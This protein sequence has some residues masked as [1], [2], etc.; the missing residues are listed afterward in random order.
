MIKLELDIRKKLDRGRWLSQK[1]GQTIGHHL[2]MAP[3]VNFELFIGRNSD[4]V[5]WV[6]QK[7]AKN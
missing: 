1:I 3:I 5:R 7:L 4:K 2:W 6:G